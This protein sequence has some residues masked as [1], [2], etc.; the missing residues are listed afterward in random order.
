[1][2]RA[3]KRKTRPLPLSPFSLPRDMVFG[4]CKTDS[5]T[6]ILREYRFYFFLFSPLSRKGIMYLAFFRRL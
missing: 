4:L 2:G 6:I 5:K 3:G 1:M